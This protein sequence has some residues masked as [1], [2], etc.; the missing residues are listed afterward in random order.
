MIYTMMWCI[1]AELASNIYTV[2]IIV[3]YIEKENLC[4]YFS[5]SLILV[6]YNIICSR[7]KERKNKRQQ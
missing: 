3:S 4:I 6:W 5:L 1:K 7:E 2:C